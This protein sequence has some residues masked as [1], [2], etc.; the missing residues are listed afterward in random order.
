VRHAWLLLFLGSGCYSFST[1]QRARTI[2]KG[3]VQVF[4]APDLLLVPGGSTAAGR[5][6]AEGGARVG[7]T[8]ALDLEGRI[9]TL[10]FTAG[11]HVQVRRGETLDVM[12]APGLAVTSPDKLALELPAPFGIEL[13]HDNQL[14]LT[15]RLVYQMRF[16]APGF[17]RPISFW[18]AG[19]SVGFAWR[20]TKSFT[21]LPELAAL[22]QIYSEPGFSSNVGGTV[23]LQLS[24]GLLFDVL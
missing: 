23:G 8:D 18:F 16:G 24:F 22:T 12:L 13:G 10:G 7:V 6:V 5:P 21:F 4:A 9:T 17:D 2:G 15:P 19:A 1:L 20:V 14:V 11:A 3:H